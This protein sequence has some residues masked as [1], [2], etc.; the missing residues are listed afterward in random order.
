MVAVPQQNSVVIVAAK[1][2]KGDAKPKAA[3]VLVALK[4]GKHEHLFKCRGIPVG[5]A[6]ANGTCVVT[7]RKHAVLAMSLKT[8][9]LITYVLCYFHPQL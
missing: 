3:A 7:A 8:R 6:L 1:Q 5:L 9:K 2:P 4:N